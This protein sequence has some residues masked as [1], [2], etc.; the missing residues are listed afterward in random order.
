MGREKE[1]REKITGK[2]VMVGSSF[3]YYVDEFEGGWDLEPWWSCLV[4]VHQVQWDGREDG[5][6]GVGDMRCSLVDESMMDGKIR[7]E[8]F[9]REQRWSRGVM[10]KMD[11]WNW[12]ISWMKMSISI[13]EDELQ[14]T[15]LSIGI[16]S[17]F[18]FNVRPTD[19]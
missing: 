13:R 11:T 18:F 12:L 2:G 17:I 6:F 7:L 15:I 1:W 3:I 5:L 16:F 8:R 19:P 10:M 4:C 14:F 9:V